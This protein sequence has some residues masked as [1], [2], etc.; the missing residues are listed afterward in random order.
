MDI[1]FCY[2]QQDDWSC[3]DFYLLHR[4]LHRI[5]TNRHKEHNMSTIKSIDP[6]RLSE[7]TKVLIYCIVKYY[8]MKDIES[9]KNFKFLQHCCPLK[10]KLILDESMP[11]STGDD[12]YKKMNVIC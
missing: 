11:L 2:E 4:Q 3:D 12:V 8:D 10:D 6:E 1:K 7:I 9:M 5:F